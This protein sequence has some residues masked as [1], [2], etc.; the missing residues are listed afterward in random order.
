MGWKL[1]FKDKME[2]EKNCYKILNRIDMVSCHTTFTNVIHDQHLDDIISAVNG[3][4]KHVQ[5]ER[6]G[7]CHKDCTVK[8]ID[9]LT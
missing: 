7:Y 9:D 3:I 6:Y 1:E 4:L 2:I 5:G 8:K